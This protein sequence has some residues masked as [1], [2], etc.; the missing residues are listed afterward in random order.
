MLCIARPAWEILL[1][2]GLAV[3]G[4]ALW[5]DHH[6][7]GT[8]VGDHRQPKVSGLGLSEYAHELPG[9]DLPALRGGV[10][11]SGIVRHVAVWEDR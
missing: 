8:S 6:G 9:A 11:P 1:P 5:R 4:I 7:N 10:D 3:A 2:D